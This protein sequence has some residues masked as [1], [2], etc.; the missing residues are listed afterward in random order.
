MSF[1]SKTLYNSELVAHPS[2]QARLLSDLPN[3]SFTALEN[4]D[5]LLTE[6]VIFYDTAGASMYER[7]EEDASDG[8]SKKTIDGESKSNENEADIVMKFIDELVSPSL[9][10]STYRSSLC[11]VFAWLADHS[12]RPSRQ[13]LSHNTLCRPIKPFKITPS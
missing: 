1:P 12:G 6:S 9:V 11:A 8:E 13:Y 5:G 4:D 3:L 2:V 10:A 7:A